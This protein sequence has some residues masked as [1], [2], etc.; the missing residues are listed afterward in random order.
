MLSKPE[1]H[2]KNLWLSKQSVALQILL[3]R[4]P[5]S[6]LASTA[7]GKGSLQSQSTSTWRATHWPTHLKKQRVQCL[8]GIIYQIVPPEYIDANIIV[9]NEATKIWTP[10]SQTVLHEFKTL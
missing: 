9:I 1:I 6:P 2:W 8:S 10:R 4:I 5:H 3:A 7:S